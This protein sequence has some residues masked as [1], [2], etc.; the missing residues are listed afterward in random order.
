MHNLC[1]HV[2]VERGLDQWDICDIETFGPN[3]SESHKSLGCMDT[4]SISLEEGFPLFQ[5]QVILPNTINSF[6]RIR[7]SNFC[8]VITASMP[9][10]QK[11]TPHDTCK[12]IH[13]QDESVVFIMLH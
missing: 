1:T 2:E 12:V 5:Q 6:R 3:I 9:H 4:Y 10:T 11:L 8:K 7:Q 13:I